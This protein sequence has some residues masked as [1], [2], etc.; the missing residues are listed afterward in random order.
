ML[1]ILFHYLGRLLS[2]RTADTQHCT[3]CA[4]NSYFDSTGCPHRTAPTSIRLS[5]RYATSIQQRVYQSRAHKIDELT[6]FML[7]FWR[8]MVQTS[9]RCRR[10]WLCGILFQ[11]L[12]GCLTVLLDFNV[13]QKRH[14]LTVL[15]T[16]ISATL[17]RYRWNVNELLQTLKIV[18]FSDPLGAIS[19][20]CV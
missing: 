11:V 1:S 10:N 6:Q 3:S 4:G 16:V 9:F 2:Y 7:H 18:K 15:L 20:V 8:G 17:C 19:S 13:A 12:C 5:T 14:S